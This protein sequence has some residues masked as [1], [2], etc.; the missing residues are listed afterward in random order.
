LEDSMKSENF[1]KLWALSAGALIFAAGQSAFAQDAAAR[2]EAGACVNDP[3]CPDKACGGQVCDYTKGPACVPAGTG[4]KGMDGWCTTD[5]DCKCKSLGATCKGFY[6]T[7]TL[8]KDAPAGG[9]GGSSGTGGSTGSGGTA[10]GATA[11]APASDSGG[12][13]MAASSATG[14]S[15]AGLL[16]GIGALAFGIRRRRRAA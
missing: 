10:G 11:P 12:C 4:T 6:C 16:V 15:S 7:F 5:D 14:L 1:R 2:A 8:A 9:A 3:D 13:A